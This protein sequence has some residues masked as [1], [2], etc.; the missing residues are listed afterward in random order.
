MLLKLLWT[1]GLAGAAL[2]LG[3]YM[4]KVLLGPN[5]QKVTTYAGFAFYIVLLLVNPLFSFLLWIVAAPYFGTAGLHIS[6]TVGIPDISLSRLILVLLVALLMAQIAT[7]RRK[8]VRLTRLDLIVLLSLFGVATS[9]F[10]SL[11]QA[12]SLAWFFESFLMPVLTYFI[13]R[14]LITDERKLAGAQRALILVGLS[15][16]LVVIQEQLMGYSWFPAAG[17]TAST[18][19]GKHLHRA[20]GLLGNP[21]F[22]AVNLSMVLPFAWR[23]MIQSPSRGGR[24][25]LLLC[26]GV[27]YVGLFMTYNR[28][29]WAGGVLGILIMLLFYPRFRKPFIRLAPLIAIPAVVYWAQITSSYAISERLVAVNPINYR[30]DAFATASR[31][32]QRN[33]LLGIGFGNMWLIADLGTPHNSFIW[34]LLSAGIVGFIPYVGTFAMMGWDSLL[35]YLRA[36]KIAGLDRELLVAFWVT[37][38]AYGAQLVAVDMLY[39][40]YCNI[41]FYFIAGVVFG[42]Q[43]AMVERAR[44]AAGAAA[45][46]G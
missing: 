16:A 37:L 34:M 1:L 17:S 19:Y 12:A 27:M 4:G 38:A 44:E 41:V 29:G 9:I 15:M 20:T 10:T 26:I 42:H 28:A 35:L 32:I 5:W 21:A 14:N 25:L 8:M 23:A 24:R 33:P 40:I 6:L 46:D 43:E 31:V 11:L 39:G 18:S 30:L 45:G 3:G 13:A 22:L 2:A 36:P 7:G